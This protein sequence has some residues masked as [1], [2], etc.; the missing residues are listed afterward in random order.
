MARSKK[1][2]ILEEQ[3]HDVESKNHVVG[4]TIKRFKK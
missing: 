2:M 4:G 3:F 1:N